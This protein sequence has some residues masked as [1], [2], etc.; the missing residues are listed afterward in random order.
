MN[1]M[2][3][4]KQCKIFWH[5]DDIKILHV[6]SNVVDVV[7][8]HLTIKYEKVSAL[9]ISRGHVYDY[10]GIRLNYGTKVKVR[11]TMP[12]HIKGIL[13]PAAEDMD[14]IVET[15]A[16]NHLFTEREYG[17]TLTGTQD[18]LFRNLVAKIFFVSFRSRPN[19]KTALAFLTTR[20]R[21]TDRDEYKKLTR[22][23]RYIREMQVMNLTLEAESMGT[24]LWWINAAYSVNLDLKVHSG[25]MILLKESVADSKSSRHRINSR[26]STESDIIGLYNNM[27]G[28]IW[29]LLL[30]ER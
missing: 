25:G 2:V 11:I 8:S 5:V 14:V 3:D 1:K 10:L 16:A 21:N 20:V 13:E 9:S 18:D 22:I 4:G 23:I 24:I 27:P 30:L 28:V 6:R 26:S 12:K 29:T 17:Y 7:L 19:L 15:P